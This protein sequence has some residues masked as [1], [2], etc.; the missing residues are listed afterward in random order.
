M[1]I[2]PFFSI[3]IPVYNRPTEIDELLN[4]L[5]SQTCKDFEVLI[6]EDGSSITCKNEVDKYRSQL[7]LSYFFKTN[8]GRVIARNF[9]MT[10]AQGSYFIIFDSDCIIPENYIAIVQQFVQ[11]HQVDCFG[12]PDA[13][14]PSFS[15]VQKAISYSMTSFLT[16]GGIRGGNKKVVKFYPRSFNMGIHRRIWEKIGGFPMVPLAEDIEYS[17]RMEQVGF[18]LR[19]IPE[20]FVYHKRRTNFKQFYRQVN[21]FGIGRIDLYK[22]FPST[23]KI[24]HFIP[25][26]FTIYFGIAI[27]LSPW[28]WL[29]LI[30]LLAYY[31]LL[32]LHASWKHHSTYIAYLSLV[33]TTVQMLG[34]GTGFIKAYLL[35]VVLNKG[36]FGK[37]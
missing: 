28:C 12:G 21:R 17:F 7:N 15:P 3:I 37:Y 10:Q 1:S 11:Q 2:A 5:C 36:A 20:A 29:V 33:A 22:K 4:S 19:L 35:R 34:Y 27:L 26:L 14:H 30:P 16:T 32:F 8:E 31:C 24:S 13:A 23:L 25:A 18:S 6:I 9:G